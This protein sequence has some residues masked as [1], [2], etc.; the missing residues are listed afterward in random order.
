MP[1]SNKD[2]LAAVKLHV[3]SADLPQNSLFQYPQQSLVVPSCY[4]F[5]AVVL[6]KSGSGRFD[7]KLTKDEM[8]LDNFC[9]R[10]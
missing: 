10:F 4:H 3:P 1:L 7:K 6:N 5:A 2:V 8:L 9:K